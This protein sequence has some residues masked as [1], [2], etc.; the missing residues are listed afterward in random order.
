MAKATETASGSAAREATREGN[1][2]S[3]P[4]A[5]MRKELV[6][7]QMYETAAKLFA[8]RGFAGTS[9]QDIADAMGIT[10]PALYYYVKSKEDLLSRLVTEIT[11]G[12]TAQILQVT[13]NK[14]IDPVQKLSEVAYL[15]AH[16]R[17]LQPTRFLLLARSEAELPEDL[18]KVHETTKRKMLRNLIEVIQAGIDAGQ[19]RPV[20]PRIAA[21]AVIGMC[22]W[23]A[24]WFHEGDAASAE[25]VATDVADM[26]VA[27]VLQAENRATAATGPRAA[28]SLLRQDVAYLERLLDDADKKL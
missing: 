5:S 1:A 21:L 23:V 11:A 15:M 12:N 19:F 24:W 18:A 2:Q 28:L 26:A 20:N 3:P 22:N 6:E 14:T 4:A 25:Q 17:A 13:T 8:E 10:R 27:S 16:N 7:N 9:L